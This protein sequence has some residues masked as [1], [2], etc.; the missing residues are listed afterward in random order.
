MHDN[1][2]EVCILLSCP[3]CKLTKDQILEL[4]KNRNLRG[5]QHKTST[6]HSHA[7]GWNETLASASEASVKVCTRSKRCY[8]INNSHTGRQVYRVTQ[9]IT[10]QNCRIPSH[11]PFKRWWRWPFFNHSSLLAWWSLWTIIRRRGQRRWS[12][13]ATRWCFGQPKF[14]RG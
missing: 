4:E 12:R 13:L 7:P 10:I 9:W 2:P 6:P 11:T 8:P 3:G 14:R 1:D 5:V